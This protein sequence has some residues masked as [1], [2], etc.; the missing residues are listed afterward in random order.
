VLNINQQSAFNNCTGRVAFSPVC[1]PSV[2][3]LS[4]IY[5]TVVSHF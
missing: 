3:H 2:A 5:P 1:R 4:V